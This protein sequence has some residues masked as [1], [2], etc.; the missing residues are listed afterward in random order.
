[1]HNFVVHSNESACRKS[2]RLEMDQFMDNA[3][4]R[5]ESWLGD[6][7]VVEL[8]RIIVEGGFGLLINEM[9]TPVVVEGGT[10]I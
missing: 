6:V 3:V 9:I 1:M 8:Y 4:L 2:V 5:G 7:V 10:E